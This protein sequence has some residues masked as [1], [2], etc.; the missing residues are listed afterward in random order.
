MNDLQGLD[1]SLQ[2]LIRSTPADS[3][4]NRFS[5]GP[6]TIQTSPAI[7]IEVVCAAKVPAAWMLA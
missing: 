2:H 5:L 3:C 4:E 6:S 7:L 1:H